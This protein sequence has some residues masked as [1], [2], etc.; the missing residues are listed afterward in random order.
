MKPVELIN[1][2]NNLID[3]K[4]FRPEVKNEICKVIRKAEL[5]PYISDSMK[6]EFCL[7]I[8]KTLKQADD[9]EAT[10]NKE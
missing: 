7:D 8:L 2:L 4:Q 6:F 5:L 1:S 3:H 10:A 9:T